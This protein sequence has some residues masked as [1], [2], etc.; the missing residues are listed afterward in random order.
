MSDS[1]LFKSKQD[2]PPSYVSPLLKPVSSEQR[3]PPSPAPQAESPNGPCAL[4]EALLGANTVSLAARPFAL[5]VDT[6]FRPPQQQA[7]IDERL[8]DSVEASQHQAVARIWSNSP[9][10]VVS[11]REQNW[12]GF[13]S[14]VARLTQR[15]HEIVMRRTGGTAVVHSPGVLNF[16]L[17]YHLPDVD[18]FSVDASYALLNTQ[19]IRFLQSIGIAATQGEVEGAYC[20][21][22][23]DIVSDGRK[24][25]GTAQRVKRIASGQNVLS[26]LSLNVCN[27][28]SRQD[29]IIDQY[30]IDC[31]QEFEITP[32]VTTSVNN[33]LPED[34]RFV[35]G[36][37]LGEQWAD[38]LAGPK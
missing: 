25:A 36:L 5:W 13:A 12:P 16:S 11:R 38:F 32:D 2:K 23:F 34:K 31:E 18:I 24:L 35:S 6:R 1:S 26:H 8:L 30:Y 9:S 10:L 4:A 22:R 15:G 28:L 21:G 29:E 19:L 20:P 33:L 7:D 14:A 27:A 3:Y 17:C 37:A